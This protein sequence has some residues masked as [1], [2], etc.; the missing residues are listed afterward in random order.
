MKKERL[1]VSGNR[2][3]SARLVDDVK[4]VGVV[5][6]EAGRWKIYVGTAEGSCLHGHVL[7]TVATRQEILKYIGRFL[8]FYR[9]N[10]KSLEQTYDFVKLI[11]IEKLRQI[12]VEDSNGICA[13][14]D[15][16]IERDAFRDPWHEEATAIHPSQFV[17]V[18]EPVGAGVSPF[19]RKQFRSSL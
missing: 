1:V 13:R 8:Q 10:G 16:E 12:L 19:V 9:E 4:D 2:L 7:C 14:L 5:T 6:V 17:D 3:G 15:T 18:L 11:S